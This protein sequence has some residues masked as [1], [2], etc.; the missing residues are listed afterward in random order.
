[1]ATHLKTWKKWKRLNRNH[2]EIEYYR[3]KFIVKIPN[4]V[5][6]KG[7]IAV[8][9][10]VKHGPGPARK[11]LREF[12]ILVST[13]KQFV[14]SKAKLPTSKKWHLDK[15]D[16]IVRAGRLAAR[17]KVAEFKGKTKQYIA[18]KLLQGKK[19]KAAKSQKGKRRRANPSPKTF[20][21]RSF[22]ETLEFAEKLGFKEPRQMKGKKGIMKF[23]YEGQ[24]YEFEDIN[25]EG[26][27]EFWD[28]VEEDALDHIEVKGYVIQ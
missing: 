28:M 3:K 11:H 20:R 8:F 9:Q 1:M 27:M 26:Y 10:G 23:R 5:D 16:R 18:T 12:Y 2:V 19:G 22:D 7:K 24:D 17:N 13:P 14:L 25:D 21:P 15:H 6:S 4:N